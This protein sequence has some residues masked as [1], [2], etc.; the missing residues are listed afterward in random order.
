MLGSEGEEGR[1][2][3]RR[4]QEAG[5]GNFILEMELEKE[6]LYGCIHTLKGQ[7]FQIAWMWTATHVL[8][9]AMLTWS[10]E[11]TINFAQ[12]GIVNSL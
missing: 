10:L 2:Q 6:G 9:A 3:E 5:E 1:R 8:C 4:R 11:V 12:D 7:L